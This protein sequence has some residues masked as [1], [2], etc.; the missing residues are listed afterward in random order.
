[1][2]K[3][4]LITYPCLLALL[5][6]SCTDRKTVQYL[7]DPKNGDVILAKLISPEGKSSYQFIKIF[8]V[9]ENQI[10]FYQSPWVY[11]E[12]PS[13]MKRNDGFV[14]KA[15]RFDRSLFQSKVDEGL[16]VKVF[17]NYDRSE[18][19]PFLKLFSQDEFR[20]D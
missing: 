5:L 17:R 16:F 3:K 11:K 7:A 20:P 14:A 1:M 12:K 2:G 15:Y 8:L 19:S 6:F 10:Y 9:E 13:T 4:V 18:H